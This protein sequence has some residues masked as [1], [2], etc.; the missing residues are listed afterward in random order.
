MV[1]L[2][3]A[4]EMTVH[5]VQTWYF[6]SLC[7]L[8]KSESSCKHTHRSYPERHHLLKCTE[9]TKKAFWILS[10]DSWWLT[11]QLLTSV[12]VD[13]WP[14]SAW[15]FKQM[16]SSTSVSLKQ[17]PNADSLSS[18]V[19]GELRIAAMMDGKL[20]EIPRGLW[21]GVQRGAGQL[22]ICVAVRSCAMCADNRRGVCLGVRG[23]GSVPQHPPVPT[24]KTSFLCLTGH[25]L[26]RVF[27]AL[28]VCNLGNGGSGHF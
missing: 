3:S 20:L 11:S 12:D 4:E 6:T 23:C 26:L 27:L 17:F 22:E 25:F 13:I 18:I 5:F 24:M 14:Q 9:E 7:L 10:A 2:L 15:N 16:F 1:V 21:L 19:T 28:Q 8:G